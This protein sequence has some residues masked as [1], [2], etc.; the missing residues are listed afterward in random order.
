MAR[1]KDEQEAWLERQWQDFLQGDVW[2]DLDEQ[3]G[4]EIQK[5]VD[6]VLKHD[7]TE[8]ATDFTRGYIC[9]MRTIRGY[10]QS[11]LIDD[12]R[13]SQEDVKETEYGELRTVPED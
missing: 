11:W 9:A 6:L 8:R 5:S 7:T 13:G 10:C 2:Q 1:D 3:I 4:T 12:S